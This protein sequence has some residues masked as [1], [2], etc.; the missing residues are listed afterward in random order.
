MSSEQASTKPRVRPTAV[1]GAFYPADAASLRTMVQRFLGEA[2]KRSGEA[3]M[4]LPRAII[5][6]HAGYSYS[7]PIAAS[8]YHRL[9]EGGQRYDRVLLIGPSHRVAFAGAATST[10]D[11]FDTPLG[12][13][14]VDR[15]AVGQIEGLAFVQPLDEA[16]AREHGLEVHLPLLIETLGRFSIVPVVVGDIAAD[17]V[18]RIIETL[19]E[20]E[21]HARRTLVVISS[22]LSH[23]HD[24]ETARRLDGATS[25]A[26]ENLS[27]QS[28]GSEQACGAVAIRA[29]LLVAQA[30]HLDA[31]TL[32]LRNSGDTAGPRDQV[33]GYGAYVFD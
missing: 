28:I 25:R 29:M 27:P 17:D 1:A 11:V 31:H 32:D 9:L 18:A 14:P 10:A 13:V 8:A 26:I 7:G 19:W 24:Y 22:D 33:V 2:A 23:Y 16:H 4:G 12:Q 5:A 15:A 20:G 3:G 6:P 30:S 21:E